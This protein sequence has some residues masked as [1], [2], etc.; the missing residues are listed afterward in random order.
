VFGELRVAYGHQ[1]IEISNH[2]RAEGHPSG[3]WPAEGAGVHNP[4]RITAANLPRAISRPQIVETTLLNLVNFPSLIATYAT[5]FRHFTAAAAKPAAIIE[6]GLRR[7]QVLFRLL[8]LRRYS[9]RHERD[10]V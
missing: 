10:L 6:F 2:C 5:R 8:F 1:R 3:V 9:P 4:Q 7:A